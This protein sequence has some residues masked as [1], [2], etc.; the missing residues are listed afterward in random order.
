MVAS[1]WTWTKHV[2]GATITTEPVEVY[3]G[4]KVQV[5]VSYEPA[6]LLS[7]HTNASA[8]NYSPS[9]WSNPN[10]GSPAKAGDHL[11]VTGT[12]AGSTSV[13]L[14]HNDGLTKT[15]Y[16]TVLAL[17]LVHFV[18]NIHGET[19]ANVVATV[20]GDGWTVTTTLPTPTHSAVDDP[21]GS[22]NTC[23]RQHLHLIGWIESEWADAHPNAEPGDITGAGAGNYYAAGANI[24]L[25][26]QNG[27]TFYAVWAKFE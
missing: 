3:V 21:G 10:L 26:A 24:D 18:D 15:I 2:G 8:Y 17:P 12:N 9:P 4:Q 27:K 13:V 7:N 11:T 14:N 6:G 5:D 25:V 22:Y 23:E 20:S 19:F 1:A 16:Y